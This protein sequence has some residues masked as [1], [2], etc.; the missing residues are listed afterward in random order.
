MEKRRALLCNTKKNKGAM[1]CLGKK[2]IHKYLVL[3]G[4]L[5]SS[6]SPLSRRA[7]PNQEHKQTRR[8]HCGASPVRC[9][10]V[11]GVGVGVLEV[12]LQFLTP[13]LVSIRPWGAAP[14]S[15]APGAARCAT[16]AARPPRFMFPPDCL[17]TT[18][19]AA[20]GTGGG[21]G[22]AGTGNMCNFCPFGRRCDS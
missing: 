20:R 10:C 13:W 19:C 21:R 17:A 18:P 1:D 14:Q 2:T 15:I 16:A 22:V 8:A 12:M 3:W 5:A 11:E 9:R 4:P 7:P 6:Y